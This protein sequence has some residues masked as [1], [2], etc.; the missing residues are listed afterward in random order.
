MKLTCLIENV[1]YRGGLAGEHGLALHIDTG[2]HKILFDTGQTGAFC[3]N[4][5]RLGVDLAEVDAVVISHGHYDHTGGLKRFM[6]INK[7]ATIFG[8]Q[9]IFLGKFNGS[10]AISMPLALSDFGG[11]FA[12]LDRDTELFPG[13]HAMTS[14]PVADDR[15][16]HWK[17]FFTE[18]EEQRQPDTFDD[19]LFLAITTGGKLSV[20]SSC[21]HRGITNIMRAAL[22]RFPLPVDL[23][24]GGF[25]LKDC[26]P[27]RVSPVIAY[28]REISP[29]RLGINHCTGIEHYAL[30]KQQFPTQAF[31]LH[32]GIMV[33]L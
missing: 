5:P 27:E 32:T 3:L 15:D 23:V 22:G 6:E 11:R 2:Q 4:A 18:R 13:I 31:Y 29:S 1:V 19:E 14:I 9:G 17:Y 26:Q 10:K 16:T 7:K 20:L 28:L 33:E 25:H 21:S 12:A 8:K 24:A 30:F